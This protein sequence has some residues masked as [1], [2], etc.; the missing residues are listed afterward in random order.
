MQFALFNLLTWAPFLL[1]GPWLAR[2]YLGGAPAWGLVTAAMALGSVLSGLALVGRRP[3]RRPLIVAAVGTYGY[4]VPCLMLSLRLPLYAVPQEM[5]ARV[6][7]FTLTGAYALGSAGLAVIGPVA[8]LI[9]A[10]PM[11]GFA[12]AYN[13]LSSTAALATRA[14][15]SVE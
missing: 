14:I 10:G 6:N 13:L 7:A 4:G 5:L 2:Q 1:L 15:R 11:L 9:G 3:P 8:A 12:A